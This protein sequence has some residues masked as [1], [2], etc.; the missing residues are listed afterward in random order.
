V[1]PQTLER[2]SLWRPA[3]SWSVAYRLDLE[4]ETHLYVKGTPRQRS[5]VLI[6]HHLSRLN[7]AGVPR[8]LSIDLLPAA[9]W[10]W[11]LLED[12]GRTPTNKELTL[13]Q[14]VE[15]AQALGQIQRST[16]RDVV[17]LSLLP[18]CSTNHL[19]TQARTIP[20]PV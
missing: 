10:R 16:E 8:V 5:E 20:F 7:S 4:D 9:P 3:I 15:V 13:P 11:F 2:V 18:D 17:L 12:A 14:E 6:T 1:V 19:H